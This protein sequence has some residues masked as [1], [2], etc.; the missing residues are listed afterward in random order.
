MTH[1]A[2]T[3]GTWSYSP[4][5]SRPACEL[6][7]ADDNHLI[8]NVGAF[9]RSDEENRANARLIAAAPKLLAA[10]QDA[11]REI[12]TLLEDLTF[13]PGEDILAQRTLTTIR[14]AL[15]EAGMAA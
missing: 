9:K 10:L 12:E 1:Q 8:A 4:E 6:V 13:V 14:E 7:Y 2:F 11:E 3:P 15:A 5:N